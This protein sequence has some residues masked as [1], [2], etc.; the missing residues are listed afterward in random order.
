MNFIYENWFFL[1]SYLHCTSGIQISFKL[2]F[3]FNLGVLGVCLKVN[4]IFANAL[5]FKN[6]VLSNFVHCL[7]I[8]A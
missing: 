5:V 1:P 7:D 2:G 6:I 8:Y 3:P 4:E